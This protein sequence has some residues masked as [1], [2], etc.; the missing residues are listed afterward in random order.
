M[1]KPRFAHRELICE[2][3]IPKLLPIVIDAHIFPSAKE[4]PEVAGQF[5]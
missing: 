3:S 1:A 2:G 4:R 5:F